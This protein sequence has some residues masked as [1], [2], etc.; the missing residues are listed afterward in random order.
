MQATAARVQTR[1]SPGRLISQAK[2]PAK[3][4]PFSTPA[5]ART[6]HPFSPAGVIRLQRGIG[7]RRTAEFIVEA[8]IQREQDRGAAPDPGSQAT[9]VEA[10]PAAPA[11]PPAPS[12]PSTP[13]SASAPAAPAPGA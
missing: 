6:S 9:Q 1:E 13:P 5:R 2:A 3:P 8:R 11:A 12:A 7:N 10:A 4:A